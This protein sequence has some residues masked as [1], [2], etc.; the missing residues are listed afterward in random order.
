M[1]KKAEYPWTVAST[2]DGR[3][4]YAVAC[5]SLTEAKKQFRAWLKEHDDHPDGPEFTADRLTKT[6][7]AGFYD[8]GSGYVIEIV[9]GGVGVYGT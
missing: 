3:F 6:V 4:N 5:K 1:A 7:N 2:V 9:K 8:D